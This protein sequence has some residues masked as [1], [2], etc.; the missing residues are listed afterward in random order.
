MTNEATQA[1]TQKS[2]NSNS[3]PSFTIG[4][5]LTKATP[6]EQLHPLNDLPDEF[7]ISMP[8]TMGYLGVGRSKLDDLVRSKELKTIRIG[9]RRW[10]FAGDLR[11]FVN[12][13]KQD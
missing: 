12:K 9:R 13:K 2:I 4:H 10:T 11:T 3:Q 7:R 8:D 5:T 1:T 6:Q